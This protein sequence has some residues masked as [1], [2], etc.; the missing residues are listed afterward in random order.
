MLLGVELTNNLHVFEV[1][2]PHKARQALNENM[3]F[4]LALPC[5]LSVWEESGEVKIGMI[6][7]VVT[8]HLLSDSPAMDGLAEEVQST[9]MA[10]IMDSIDTKTEAAV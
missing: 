3:I 4:S 10:I 1:C 8:L 6:D 5:R 7:P 9:M 2:N